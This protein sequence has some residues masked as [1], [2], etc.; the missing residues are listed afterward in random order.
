MKSGGVD[1]VVYY[2]MNNLEDGCVMVMCS[3]MCKKKCKKRLVCMDFKSPVCDMYK[4]RCVNLCSGVE[5]HD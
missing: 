1:D 5:Y 4:C 2:V 3:S